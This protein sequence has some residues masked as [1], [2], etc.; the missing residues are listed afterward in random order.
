MAM[1]IA[2]AAMMIAHLGWAGELIPTYRGRTRVLGAVQ[3]AS[4]I[5]QTSMLLLAAIVVQGMGGTD[6]DA[7]ASMGWTLLLLLPLTTFIAVKFAPEHRTPP[8]PHLG[9]KEALRTLI[10][11]PLV[12]RVLAPDLLLGIAQG[13]SGTLFLFYFQFVLGFAN[14][15][16]TLLAIY[17]IAG[18]AGVPIWWIAGQRIGKHRAL[19]VVFLY[20]AAT[21]AFIALLP[22]GAFTLA[23]VLMILAGLA[24]GGGVLLTRSLM[25]DVVDSDELNTGARRSGLYFGLLLTTS[26][27]G[28]ATGPLFLLALGWAGFDPD[29]AAINSA[30]AL[31]MLRIC[32]IGAPVL[33]CI[34]AAAVL[35]KYP[36]DEHR[37]AE[38]AAAITARTAA[39][40]T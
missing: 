4:M 2:F 28:L 31:D 25:A 24:Q 20:T 5:G 1:Y 18:L 12:R 6:A 15:S 29:P 35:R 36:L 21:T 17:F 32:F 11:N 9:L 39:S 37:H 40:E 16:Q 33:L 38:I 8:Q 22:P 30:A 27:I 7:V 13:V 34:A 23:I 26:K 14:Q 19:Q 10:E 3:L